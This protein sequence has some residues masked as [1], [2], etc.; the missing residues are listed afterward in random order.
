MSD[1]LSYGLAVPAF[2]FLGFQLYR[3]DGLRVGG[4]FFAAALLCASNV[5][6]EYA[7]KKY[8]VPQT[9]SGIRS[10]GFVGLLMMAG[11]H[12]VKTYPWEKRDLEE[13]AK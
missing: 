12:R 10:I 8:H 13:E 3:Q 9:Y 5:L 2:T 7:G 4:I 1:I 6:L 11:G